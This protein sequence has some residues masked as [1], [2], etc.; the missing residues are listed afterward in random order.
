[1]PLGSMRYLSKNSSQFDRFV[2]FVDWA[3]GDEVKQKELADKLK[4]FDQPTSGTKE[5]LV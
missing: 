3:R 2:K 1:M 4:E 5:N